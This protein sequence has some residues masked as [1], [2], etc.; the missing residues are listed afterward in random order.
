MFGANNDKY[1]KITIGFLLGGSVEVSA[2]QLAYCADPILE[3]DFDGMVVAGSKRELAK[4]ALSGTPMRVGWDLD[5]TGNKQPDLTHWSDAQFTSVVSGEVATKV[6]SVHR[7]IPRVEEEKVELSAEFGR[8]HGLLD[9]RGVLLGRFE[10]SEM[11]NQDRVHT[12]WCFTTPPRKIWE[13]VFQ[14]DQAG[15]A[16]SGEKALLLDAVRS[17]QSVRLGWSE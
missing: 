11:V 9:S 10:H 14:H 8:W 6:Q 5:F 15:V 17:G 2:Q 1:K 16:I 3:V 13:M 4:V 7:Q 12:V